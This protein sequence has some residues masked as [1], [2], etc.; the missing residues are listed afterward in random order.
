MAVSVAATTKAKRAH[1]FRQA[2]SLSGGSA[3]TLSGMSGHRKYRRT[4]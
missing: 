2:R 4:F 3:C 1:R